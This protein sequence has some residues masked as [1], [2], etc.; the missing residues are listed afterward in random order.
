M[1]KTTVLTAALLCVAAPAVE[2][3]AQSGAGAGS[4]VY[5]AEV[6]GRNVRVRSG[7]ADSAYFCVEISAPTRVTV[8]GKLGTW[9]KI[10]PPKGCYSVVAKKDVRPEAGGKTGLIVGGGVFAYAGGFPAEPGRYSMLQKALKAGQSVMILG[11]TGDYHKIVP[12]SGAYFWVA[13][14]DVKQVGAA[15][16]SPPTTKPAATRPATAI[17]PPEVEYK[18]HP[19]VLALQAIDKDLK[20]ECLKPFKERD[21]EALLDK[22]RALKISKDSGVAPHV[23]ARIKGLETEIERQKDAATAASV[24]SQAATSFRDF[25]IARTKVGAGSTTRPVVVY[26]A[27]GIVTPSAIYATD[28]TI[29]RRF[30]LRDAKVLRINAYLINTDRQVALAE[31]VG[32]LVEVYGRSGFDADLGMDLVD[33]QKVVVVSDSA[34]LPDPPPPAVAAPAKPEAAKKKG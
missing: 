3:L 21:Y 34:S 29:G 11:Q 8:V 14:A 32:K 31:Y 19:D 18:P 30:V 12:P 23:A 6:L 20:A 25:E 13:A 4:S 15:T 16:V 2:G 17:K 22:Y 33:V 1:K 24:V 7:P 9:L 10:L 27:K 5:R 26:T 28:V